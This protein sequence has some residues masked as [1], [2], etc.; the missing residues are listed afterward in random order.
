MKAVNARSS[1]HK[2][3]ML[4]S[5]LPGWK[6]NFRIFLVPL[7]GRLDKARYYERLQLA[8]F[9]IGFSHAQGNLAVM[10]WPIKLDLILSPF[11]SGHRH[12]PSTS[13]LILC[14]ALLISLSGA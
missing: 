10:S 9:P 6:E 12:R 8:A 3:K 14:H 7:A 11:C 13:Y 5:V 4:F 2:L 1:T